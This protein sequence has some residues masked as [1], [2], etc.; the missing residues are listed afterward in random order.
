MVIVGSTM[1][2]KTWLTRQ[3]IKSFARNFHTITILTGTPHT[4]DW[5]EIGIRPE[6][7]S[8]PRLEELVNLAGEQYKTGQPGKFLLIVDD[9]IGTLKSTRGGV[10]GK[11]GTSGR[12]YGITS[13]WLT[14]DFNFV[15]KR[16]RGNVQDWIIMGCQARSVIKGVEEIT[17]LSK[18]EF[19]TKYAELGE[20]DFLHISMYGGNKAVFSHKVPNYG[21]V[22]R[23]IQSRR[24]L[25]AI[26]FS[27]ETAMRVRNEER[28]RSQMSTE[29]DERSLLQETRSQSSS[30]ADPN[31]VV[32]YHR[33]PPE[34][35]TDTY[36]SAPT[37]VYS[38]TPTTQFHTAQLPT[39][40][41][42]Q[43]PSTT[44]VSTYPGTDG[45]ERAASDAAS[46][47]VRGIRRNRTDATTASSVIPVP[48][49]V[50]TPT[51]YPSTSVSGGRGNGG[52]RSSI[53]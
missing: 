4:N 45:S 18:K 39:Q 47:S 15:D 16:I 38:S 27:E 46:G 10:F 48:P 2:G 13:I 50:S 52:I 32:T 28:K 40:L 21:Y 49:P 53:L 33:A 51:T 20:Y 9:M 7:V 41:P 34:P 11:L 23:P 31:T 1:S 44:T 17:P 35:S 3:L 22:E 29:R 19:D 43:H 26:R 37:T 24:E 36:T 8:I 12:H 6:A 5:T 14:Q 42:T 25:A 30:S